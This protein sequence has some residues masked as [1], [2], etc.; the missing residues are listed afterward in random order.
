MSLLSA[1]TLADIEHSEGSTVAWADPVD[2]LILGI[3]GGLLLASSG[4]GTLVTDSLG[5]PSIMSLSLLSFINFALFNFLAFKDW[6][7]IGE[8]DL[9]LALSKEEGGDEEDIFVEATDTIAPSPE[10]DC[11]ELGIEDVF[12]VFDLSAV[13]STER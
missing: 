6:S 8:L 7:V 1:D 9:E 5:L 13:F 10:L 2:N 12:E 11:G 4:R 3:I